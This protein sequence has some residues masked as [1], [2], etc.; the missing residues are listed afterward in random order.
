MYPTGN[1][2]YSILYESYVQIEFNGIIIRLN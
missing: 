1:E 2:L